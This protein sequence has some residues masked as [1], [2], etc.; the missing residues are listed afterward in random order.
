MRT[1]LRAAAPGTV[2]CVSLRFGAPVLGAGVVVAVQSV[3]TH[4]AFVSSR[5]RAGAELTSAPGV[6]ELEFTEPL[7][8]ELSSLAVTDPD[9]RTW[10]RTGVDER[11]M[12]AE[13]A[14][15]IPGVYGVEWKSDR[16]S[17]SATATTGG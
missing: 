15:N 9:G 8:A 12:Q 17:I 4:A 10:E 6:V 14:T 1:P 2:R 3:G 11:S 5:P 13:L 7:I 16:G